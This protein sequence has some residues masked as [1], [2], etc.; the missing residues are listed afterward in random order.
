M[1]N[2]IKN[3]PINFPSIS[4]PLGARRFFY[5]SSNSP[6]PTI[7]LLEIGK[8]R[9]P[10]ILWHWR[11]ILCWIAAVLT[12]I[13]RLCHSF[14]RKRTHLVVQ[15]M[16]ICMPIV[17]QVRHPQL[18]LIITLAIVQQKRTEITL[19]SHF[20]FKTWPTLVASWMTPTATMRK[21]QDTPYLKR[22]KEKTWLFQAHPLEI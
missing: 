9:K 19:T 21:A 5:A 4:C 20:S 6:K 7:Q 11:K 2:R 14:L 18:K 17:T 16:S 12:I 8:E 15:T 10:P 13:T 3:S 1:P 22:C